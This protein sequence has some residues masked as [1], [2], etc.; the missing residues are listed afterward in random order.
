VSITDLSARTDASAIMPDL[1]VTIRSFGIDAY[2]DGKHEVGYVN[3]AP[4][5]KV[6][7]KA[8]NC[9]L[10]TTRPLHISRGV[11]GLFTG[12]DAGGSLCADGPIKPGT[13]QAYQE[14]VVAYRWTGNC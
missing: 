8:T 11:V 6:D 14:I 10:E 5:C 9:V 13:Y 7:S 2:I 3:A 4:L 12:R 1:G